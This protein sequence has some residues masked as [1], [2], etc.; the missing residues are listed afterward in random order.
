MDL[1]W[2]MR[3]G[4]GLPP[5]ERERLRVGLIALPETGPQDGLIDRDVAEALVGLAPILFVSTG[6]YHPEERAVLESTVWDL[7]G[8]VRSSLAALDAPEPSRSGMASADA[9]YPRLADAFERAQGALSTG[10]GLDQATI[11]R[12]NEAVDACGDAWRGR[13]R[14]PIAEVRVLFEMGTALRSLVGR[15]RGPAPDDIL[16]ELD[17]LGARID[18]TLSG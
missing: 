14:L 2:S 4:G 7:A 17:D 5:E 10:A 9:T 13:V 3:T 8:E 16:D 12:M 6:P 18:R 15:Q 1:A 11:E